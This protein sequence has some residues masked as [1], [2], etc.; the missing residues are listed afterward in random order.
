MPVLFCLS[1]DPAAGNGADILVYVA[2]DAG[3]VQ[4]GGWRFHAT[5]NWEPL[6]GSLEW[7]FEYLLPTPAGITCWMTV[8]IQQVSNQ[9]TETHT[10][11]CMWAP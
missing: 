4:V 10:P 9:I 3:L 11:T 6:G 5:Q 1:Q 7:S 2:S 8:T